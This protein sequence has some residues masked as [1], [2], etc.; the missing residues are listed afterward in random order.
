M[1]WFAREEEGV[2]GGGIITFLKGNHDVA[3]WHERREENGV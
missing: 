3:A 1:R 2:G